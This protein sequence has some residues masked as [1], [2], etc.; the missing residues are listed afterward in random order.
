[1]KQVP[2]HIREVDA[3]IHV[4]RCFEDDN[5]I[6][7]D[8]S[9]DPQRDIETI[10]LELILSDAE[11]L[12]AAL[13]GYQGFKGR[14]ERGEILE[15]FKRSEPMITASRKGNPLTDEEKEI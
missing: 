2:F 1:M 4:V 8:G 12:T 6:H 11:F 5:I 7:V 13:T 3:V 9:V 15:V 10:N 14:Q